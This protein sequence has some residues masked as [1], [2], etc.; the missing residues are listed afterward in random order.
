MSGSG[1][2]KKDD[3]QSHQQV[4]KMKMKMKTRTVKAIRDRECPGRAA[5]RLKRGLKTEFQGTQKCN[6]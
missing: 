1:W 5:V 3:Y 4:M 2:S 6:G